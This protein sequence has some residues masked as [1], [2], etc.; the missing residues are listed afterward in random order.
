MRDIAII[1][2][3]QS[4]NKRNEQI[5]NEAEILAPVAREALQKAGL[6]KEEIDFTCSGSSDY[7]AGQPFSFVIALNA[8]GAWPPIQE[9]HV[10]ADAAW[11]LYECW[12]AMQADES[13][14]TSLVY[15]FGKQSMGS[16]RDVMN[17]LNDPYVETP[18]WCDTI[19]M[20]ALQG[21]AL[22]DAGLA[23]ERD[24]AAVA[25][26]NLKHAKSNPKAQ[27]K[28]DFTVDELLR[29]PTLASPLRKH[30]C[31]PITDGA[32][33]VILAAG[34]TAKKLCKR[35]AWIRGI[36]HRIDVQAIGRRDLTRA[37]SAQIAAE[38][39]GVGAGKVDIAELHALF[40]PQDIILRKE[41]GLASDCV[42]NP[43]GGVHQG[44]PMMGTGLVRFGEVADRIIRGEAN[45]G[46]AHATQGPCL[47]QNMVAVL[48][49]K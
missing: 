4:A 11:A 30:D 9:S 15:G 47:Q 25:A 6:K 35:P 32:C 26:R 37:P 10:E 1:A 3:A 34:D 7:L 22:I 27:C 20:A 46:V 43:S 41:L 31:P 40:T 8:I 36:D 12:I 33:V 23:T 44:N 28:G 14:N 5:Y 2:F 48:E 39:A 49:G 45:R 16:P 18:L 24:F 29:S 17:I 38:K 42:I 19:S 13:I 21:R